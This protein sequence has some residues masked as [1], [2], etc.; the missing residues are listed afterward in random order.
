MA[1][2]NLSEC[3]TKCTLDS[4]GISGSIQ[5]F[6]AASPSHAMLTSAL[7]LLYEEKTPSYSRI[8]R[9]LKV[10]ATAKIGS[11]GNRLRLHVVIA[12]KAATPR[13]EAKANSQS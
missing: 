6:L 5:S 4:P 8:A 1:M 7:K 2:L 11:P 12:L 9:I 10:Q 13:N 3:I